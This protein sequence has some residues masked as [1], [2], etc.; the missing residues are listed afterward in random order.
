VL[1]PWMLPTPHQRLDGGVT[2]QLPRCPYGHNRPVREERLV[3]A[4]ER[5]PAGQDYT[6]VCL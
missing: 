3:A 1:Y 2:W 5:I 6:R 4:F